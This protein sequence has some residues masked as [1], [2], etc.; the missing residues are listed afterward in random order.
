MYDLVL[1]TLQLWYTLRKHFSSAVCVDSR[2]Y[3]NLLQASGLGIC[4]YSCCLG[5][6]KDAALRTHDSH[7]VSIE[8]KRQNALKRLKAN[9]AKRDLR[10]SESGQ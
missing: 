2:A 3:L 7:G 10:Q 6:G 1:S 8:E 4:M 5:A 9:L